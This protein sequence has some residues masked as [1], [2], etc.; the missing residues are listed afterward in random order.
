MQLQKTHEQPGHPTCVAISPD[1]PYNGGNHHPDPA[2][3]KPADESSL[4]VI[5]VTVPGPGYESN[6][7]RPLLV[8]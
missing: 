5:E 7:P 8:L 3:E 4:S 2:A 6:G 1:E